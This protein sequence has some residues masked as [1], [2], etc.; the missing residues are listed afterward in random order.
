[1]YT[2]QL[3]SIRTKGSRVATRKRDHQ[4][5]RQPL[6]PLS[7]TYKEINKKDLARETKLPE[8]LSLLPKPQLDLF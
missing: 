8:Q 3:I 1:L 5:E 7:H 2:D 6:L 4:H